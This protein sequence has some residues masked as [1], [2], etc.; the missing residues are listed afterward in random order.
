MKL[1]N[2]KYLV[3]VAI[4]TSA[5]V[6]GCQVGNQLT[7]SRSEVLDFQEA[8]NCGIL[9]IIG[10]SSPGTDSYGRF[11]RILA[12]VTIGGQMIACGSNDATAEQNWH[13]LGVTIER[14]VI[15]VEDRTAGT[16]IEAQPV[17]ENNGIINLYANNQLV[18]KMG[19]VQASEIGMSIGLDTG[20][21]FEIRSQSGKVE[22][23][24]SKTI[25]PEQMSLWVVK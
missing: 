2:M 1:S 17:L 8:K 13:A 19:S 24:Q 11:G 4:S 9:A 20:L 5:V 6:I 18:L 23:S 16:K 12:A 15:M 25:P 22:L 10:E 14:N 7:G 3:A 21:A